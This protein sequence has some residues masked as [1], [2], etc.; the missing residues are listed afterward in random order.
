MKSA[1]RFHLR[2]KGKQ[3]PLWMGP[4]ANK[5]ASVTLVATVLVGL[6]CS[7]VDLVSLAAHL[8]T[9]ITHSPRVEKSRRNLWVWFCV[10]CT[11]KNLKDQA[12]V[13]QVTVHVQSRGWHKLSWPLYILGH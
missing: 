6:I 8:G 3:T 2:G 13:Y 10:D 4:Q 7:E 9:H 11:R 12:C 1:P 5:H